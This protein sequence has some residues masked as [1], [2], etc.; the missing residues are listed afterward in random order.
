M[1][2]ANNITNAVTIRYEFNIVCYCCC[3]PTQNIDSTHAHVDTENEKPSRPSSA[4]RISQNICAAH[5]RSKWLKAFFLVL[6]KLM[7]IFRPRHGRLCGLNGRGG[8]NNRRTY[9][10]MR[11]CVWF[12]PARRGWVRKLTREP[13]INLC[14]TIVLSALHTS[15]PRVNGRNR[16]SDAH[17]RSLVI[18][19]LWRLSHP[20]GV[21]PLFY[22]IAAL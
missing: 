21:C 6:I 11:E 3:L 4:T 15:V 1:A 12:P 14:H 9:N 18:I 5:L 8:I 2:Q 13:S 22:Y 19:C 17:I 10:V 20:Q 16:C 7:R